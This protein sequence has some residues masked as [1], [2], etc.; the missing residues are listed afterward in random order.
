MGNPHLIVMMDS[1]DN[2]SLTTWGPLLERHKAFPS[3]TNVHFVQ[4]IDQNTI[5]LKVW[6]RGTGVTQA[7]G[8]GACACVVAYIKLNLCKGVVKAS[9][10]GGDLNIEWSMQDGHVYKTGPAQFVYNGIF[11]I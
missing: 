5:T 10:P 9:L 1:I 7:C 6:E 2:V 3:L 11:E 4:K 8:T